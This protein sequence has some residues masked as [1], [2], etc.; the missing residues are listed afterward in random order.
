MGGNAYSRE[1]VPHVCNQF[2]KLPGERETDGIAEGDKAYP[3]LDDSFTH[4]QDKVVLCARG[5]FQGEIDI[6]C[7]GTSMGYRCTSQFAYFVTRLAKFHLAMQG[8]D[9]DKRLDGGA[10]SDLHC[11]PGAIDI[12]KICARYRADLSIVYLRGNHAYSFKLAWRRDGKAA[13]EGIKAHIG[14]RFGNRQFL[15]WEVVHPRCLLTITERC[16]IELDDAWF[17]LARPPFLFM[18]HFL[19]VPPHFSLVKP[20]IGVGRIIAGPGGGS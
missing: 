7:I 20:T 4:L 13:V 11:F 1:L 2:A 14:Q 15:F 3:F 6:F 16:F 19:Q 10:V 8:R 18:L 5:I 17:H 12:S 9:T